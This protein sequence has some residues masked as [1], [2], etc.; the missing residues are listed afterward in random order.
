MNLAPQDAAAEISDA[1]LDNISGGLAIGGSG[2]LCAETPI[3]AVA[4]DL[5]AIGTPD[6]VTAGGALHIAAAH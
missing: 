2:S 1:D 4:A 3:G 6:G 5:V